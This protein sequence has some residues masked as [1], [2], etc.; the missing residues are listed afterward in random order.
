M[1]FSELFCS[2]SLSPFRLFILYHEILFLCNKQFNKNHYY[3]WNIRYFL[4]CCLLLQQRTHE[5]KLITENN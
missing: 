4:L 1:Q 2:S 3:L 5:K